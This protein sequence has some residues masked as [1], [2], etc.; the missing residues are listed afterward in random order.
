MEQLLNKFIV[1][2]ELYQFTDNTKWIEQALL[3]GINSPEKI[4]NIIVTKV[5]DNDDNKR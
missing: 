2:F 1:S 3:M 4:N 5:N